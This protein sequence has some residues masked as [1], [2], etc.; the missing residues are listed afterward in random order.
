MADVVLD[1]LCR[2]P[3]HPKRRVFVR[4][5]AGGQR[6]QSPCERHVIL[7]ANDDRDFYHGLYDNNDEPSNEPLGNDDYDDYDD[8]DQDHNNHDHNDHDYVYAGRV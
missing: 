5:I 4:Y 7:E 1:G 3:D 2:R 8:Y 6:R